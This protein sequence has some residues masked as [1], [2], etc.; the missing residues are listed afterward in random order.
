MPIQRPKTIVMEG[1]HKERSQ[2]SDILDDIA[3]QADPPD[4]TNAMGPLE[5]LPAPTIEE[6]AADEM[7]IVSFLETYISVIPQPT[8]AQIVALATA[9]SVD[10]LELQ[11]VLVGILG[12]N[13]DDEMKNAMRDAALHDN[14]GVN[15]PGD[16]DSFSYE[17]INPIGTT[18][19]QD[20]E[21]PELKLTPLVQKQEHVR[22]GER[23]M[24]QTPIGNDVRTPFFAQASKQKASMG[25]FLQPMD[26]DVLSGDPV[27]DNEPGANTIQAKSKRTWADL[28]PDNHRTGIDDGSPI[29]EDADEAESQALI[30][31]GDIDD[32]TQQEDFN[33]NR[34]IND[35]GLF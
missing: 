15:I 2:Q 28:A 19:L 3:T 25:D 17:N 7:L 23:Q 1:G 24:P 13:S 6:A 26:D 5:T 35:D 29:D 21:V 14:P 8:Q 27:E 33:N 16:L 31:D 22:P 9:I 32:E 4:N 18:N 34:Y 12:S 11:A 10:P 30:N 20:M